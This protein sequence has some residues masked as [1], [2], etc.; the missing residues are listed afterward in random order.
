[1]EALLSGVDED[2]PSNDATERVVRV[3][4]VVLAAVPLLTV[5]LLYLF[6]WDTSRTFGAWPTY[7][8]P[9]PKTANSWLYVASG[10]GV[11]ASLP[12]VVALAT[13]L[14][15]TRRLRL[16][17]TDLALIAFAVIGA[18]ALYVVFSGPLGTWYM[19]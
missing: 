11:L 3:V 18:I 14:G 7:A 8:T 19:D 10:L 15:A 2:L 16:N 4:S 1:M 12:S 13:W 17:R 5:G 9:D 6:A